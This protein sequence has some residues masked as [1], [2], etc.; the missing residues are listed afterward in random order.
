MNIKDVAKM[1]G[2]SISTIS[3]VINN[4]AY[5]SPEIKEKIEKILAET[6]YRP[7]SLAKELLRNKTNTIGVM[8][9][10]IDLG[11]FAAM[12]DGI[13][14]VL[15]ENGY[16]ILLANT[17]DQLDEELRYLNL[18]HEKR[19]DGV[20]YFATGIN[21]QHVEAISKFHKP[22]VI[23]GQSGS[24]LDCPSVRLDNFEA[25]KA[26]VNYLISLGHRR[27]GCLAVPDHDVNIGILRKEGYFAALNEN[28]IG[29]D[30]SLLIT[31]DFEYISG[32]RGAKALMEHPGG[33]PTAIYCITDRLA[34]ATCGWLL[35]RGVKV[36]EDVSVVC[37]DDPGLLS[38][39][40]PAITTMSFDYQTTGM[41]AGQMVI[42]CID[43]KKPQPYEDVMPFTMQIR[44]SAHKL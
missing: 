4:S 13:V 44:E 33:P 28:N 20:L 1:A 9:P 12:F 10:R 14:T 36:P 39:C 5:V 15:N 22:V 11:T 18:F 19:V 3:R 21:L 40:Y 17:R 41:R 2:V 37:I 34:I 8:L 42:D 25:A 6:G 31:G 43:G 30:P 27:I 16:N 32:E 7:N 35:R 38:F 23:V 26:M 24:Y 29:I